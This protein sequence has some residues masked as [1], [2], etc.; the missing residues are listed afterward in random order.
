[1]CS[2]V[3]NHHSSQSKRV[4]CNLLTQILPQSHS[5]GTNSETSNMASWS[6]SEP[7]CTT[8]DLG[9]TP[10]AMVSWWSVLALNFFKANSGVR[11]SFQGWEG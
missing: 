1:M 3:H 8:E 5:K 11:K 6:M 7:S 4:H 2:F 9:E 10:Y